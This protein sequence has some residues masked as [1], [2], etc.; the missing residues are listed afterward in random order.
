MGF[1][2]DVPMAATAAAP[3]AGPA[4][5]SGGTSRA[6]AGFFDDVPFASAGGAPTRGAA[7]AGNAT[8]EPETG[9]GPSVLADVVQGA[10]AGIIRG[11]GGLVDL[12]QTAL[13][14]ID[15]GFGL[16]T[17]PVAIGVRA[18]AGK[19]PLSEAEAEQARAAVKGGLPLPHELP[20]PG[21]AAIGALEAATGKL[22]EPQ[23]RAGKFARTAAEF[24]PGAGRKL[25]EVLALGIAPGLASEG[26]GQ[27]T[28]GSALET[29]ARIVA[30][31]GAGLG[32]AAVRARTGA[33]GIASRR[34]QGATPEQVDQAEAL[35]R[36]AAERGLPLTR[37][38]ALDAVTG[39]VTSLSDLQRVVEGTG[40]LRG[41]FAPT[42]EGVRREGEGVLDTIAPAGAN[43]SV[44][45][46]ELQDAA[47][48][49]VGATPQGTALTQ[50]LDAAGPR[51]TPEQAG[52]VIQPEL[53]QAFDRREGMRAA[54]GE[55]D[56]RAA[57]A[58]PER[59][60]IERT[61]R[62]ERPGE[63]VVTQAR[64]SRPAF[65]DE[66][67]PPLP[68]APAVE[69]AARPQS[70]LQ[71]LSRNGGIPLDAEARTAD[72]HRL[73]VPGGGTLARKEAPSWDDLRVRLTEDGFLPYDATG[74][75]S[76]A[77]VR[78]L[79]LGAI[80]RERIGRGRQ[81][82]MNDEGRP[83]ARRGQ[84][85]D[86]YRAALSEAERR[87]DTDL[88][89][90]GVPLDSVH[91]DIRSRTLNALM[92]GETTDPL[93]AFERT[94]M[95]TRENPVPFS[96]STTVSEEISAPRFGQANPQAVVDHIDEALRSAKGPV[97][98]ALE[99]ARGTLFMRAERGA[100]PELDLSVAGL[101]GAR[102]AINDMIG[103]AEPTAQRALMGVRERLDRALGT[104]PEYE[105]ARSGFEAASRNLDPFASGTVPGRIANR[106]QVSGRSTMPPEQAPAAIAE[107]PSGARDFNAVASPEARRQ[108][109]G[110]LT[111]QILDGIGGQPGAAPAQ[112]I[113]DL[114]RQRED[115]FE[116]FPVVRDRLRAVAAAHDGLEVVNR[117]PLGKIAARPD[118]QAAIEALFPTG[119]KGV[120][121]AEVRD[122]VRGLAR[123]SSRAAEDAVRM[124]V[125]QVFQGATE[126]LQSGANQAGGPKF[127]QALVGHPGEAA[128]VE[129][130]I[131]ALPNGETT[132][133]G[134][135]RLLDIFD[136][137]GK[138]QATG[139]GTSFNDTI[140]GD[141]KA[142]K[143]LAEAGTALASGGINLPRQIKDRIEAWRLGEGLDD[144][145]RL[146]TDPKMASTF[147][148]LATEPGG[149]AGLPRLV[150]MVV[151]RAARGYGSAQRLDPA[152]EPKR[153][154]LRLNVK[155]IPQGR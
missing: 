51:V 134:V 53:Q 4:P 143:P 109:E 147:R 138:R 105:A 54:L 148:R 32:G 132:W 115:V 153:E 85:S 16:I 22:Y 135:R 131:R 43:P 152:A 117:S 39:G 80:Q 36:E 108:M 87:L 136:A 111:T 146:F 133:A 95:A 56:Y 68:P 79:V 121:A 44:L 63:P 49:A 114:L 97:A 122:A 96:K 62:V 110:Q 83:E 8:P 50:A 82:R 6:Q 55:Q 1:F 151:D 47:R 27:L 37:A 20:R 93:E 123:F 150:A 28:E 88:T 34:A 84:E 91:P 19:A 29:P 78:D 149:S 71:Y 130:A 118:A 94:V 30:S 155:P 38:N 140:L 119:A 23:T 75:A 25:G 12:P 41:F 67:A 113:R 3:P 10:G 58:A 5:S 126:R 57:E 72:L 45:G 11:A 15:K 59:I 86:E 124:H 2:D 26:A 120:S 66:A 128:S 89:A 100:A 31:V 116:Q 104:V 129:A 33:E 13:G 98:K 24:V 81:V 99:A 101:H 17:D 103:K 48:A 52:R 106:D 74:A 64:P 42:A 77:D 144:L 125:E 90:A 65:T 92:R 60:G 70:I 107:G 127:S 141:L 154:P 137:Q 46:G 40:R 139:S 14:L 73:Y 7:K 35:F 21:A 69:T 76:A 102:E 112:T 61:V 9:A 142:G 145:A 18:V